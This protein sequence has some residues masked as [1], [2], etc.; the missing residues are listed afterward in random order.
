MREEPRLTVIQNRVSRRI[1]GPKREEV[2]GERRKIQHEELNDLYYSLSITRVIKSKRKRWVGH[3]ARM[4]RGEAYT[5][6]LA[7]KREGKRPL[8]RSRRRWE[9]NIRRIFRKWDVGLWTGSCWL[10]IGTGGGHL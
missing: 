9:D 6:F 8:G 10:R 4:G 7:R 3:V 1:F 2:I 5:R